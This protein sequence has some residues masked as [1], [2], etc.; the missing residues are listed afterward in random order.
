M[1]RDSTL[2][3]N[4]FP[5]PSRHHL[6]TASWLGVGPWVH[7]PF[8]VLQFHLLWT[9]A[10]LMCTSLSLWA[11]RWINPVVSGKQFPWR[12]PPTLTLSIFPPPLLHSSP[13]PWGKGLDEDIPSRTDGSQVSHSLYTVQLVS[14]LCVNSHLLHEASLMRV[15]RYTDLWVQQHALKSHLCSVL[16][17]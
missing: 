10:G 8:S 11:H 3:E 9:H 4:E 15:E 2:E 13:K 5:F 16:F 7:F 1:P 6:Q 14:G 12:H 17:A